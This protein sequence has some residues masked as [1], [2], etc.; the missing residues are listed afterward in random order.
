MAPTVKSSAK[1][2]VIPTS[3]HSTPSVT[4]SRTTTTTPQ[5]AEYPISSN[6]DQP[7]TSAETLSKSTKTSNALA[8][9]T[10]EPTGA[11]M[12]Q[13][14]W[15]LATSTGEAHP[16]ASPSTRTAP[17]PRDIM[18]PSSPQ[19]LARTPSSTTNPLHKVRPSS[20]SK[21]TSSPPTP[22]KNTQDL[23][24]LAEEKVITTKTKSSFVPQI[25]P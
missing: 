3:N 21:A 4:P 1:A 22:T 8:K 13:A 14:P 12:T 24:S 2:T 11:K 9:T 18:E 6:T 20:L 5:P 10:A 23:T 7:V 19:S 17:Y 16:R 25:S 15:M